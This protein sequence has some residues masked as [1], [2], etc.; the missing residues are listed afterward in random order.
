M[1]EGEGNVS[2]SGCFDFAP[3]IDVLAGVAGDFGAGFLPFLSSVF[4]GFMDGDFFPC[5][6]GGA[7]FFAV[8][9]GGRL[10]P[11]IAAIGSGF[12]VVSAAFLPASSL[13]LSFLESEA[14]FNS[15]SSATFGAG[16]AG[17]GVDARLIAGASGLALGVP[18][19]FEV[20][21]R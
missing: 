16:N 14:F 10:V 19:P 6:A 7:V 12:F 17:G 21:S 3:D 13:V 18:T 9:S 4:A 1:D 2:V 20:N 15:L 5:G 11:V 8:A